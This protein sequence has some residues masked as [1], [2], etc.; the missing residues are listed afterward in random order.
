MGLR[1]TVCVA[2]GVLAVAGCGASKPQPGAGTPA[3]EKAGK[4]EIDANPEGRPAFTIAKA[5]ATAG[6]VTITM[7][8][9]SG[10]PHNIAVQQGSSG[11]MQGSTPVLGA[12]KVITGGSASITVTSSPAPTR[13]SAR[14]PATV[15]GGCGAR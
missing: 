9:T 13:S 10:V 5:T 8:N 15:W 3:V 11:A 2:L 6:A 14:C 7:A 12:S 4:L 1:A